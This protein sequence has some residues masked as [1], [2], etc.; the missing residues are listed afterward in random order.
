MRRLGSSTLP[1]VG[2]DRQMSGDPM[3]HI[4]IKEGRERKRERRVERR[5]IERKKQREHLIHTQE[6]ISNLI[7]DISR[8]GKMSGEISLDRCA[9]PRRGKVGGVNRVPR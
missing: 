1:H 4:A 2:I 5:K 9:L 7:G 6:E 3:N 8:A